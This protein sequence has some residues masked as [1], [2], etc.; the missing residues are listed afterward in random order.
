M[1]TQEDAPIYPSA[2]AAK[3]SAAA[4]RRDE[5][6]SRVRW[7]WGLIGF[8]GGAG[9]HI[10][11]SLAIGAVIVLSNRGQG[12]TQSLL[13]KLM[14]PG[15]LSFQVVLT[16]GILALW[17]LGLPKAL[18]VSVKGFLKLSHA[19]PMAY[20]WSLVG[21]AACGFVVDQ[22]LFLLHNAAPQLFDTEGLAAFGR[23]FA[24]ASLGGY[25]LMTVVV[26]L[27]P[28]LGEE[29][30]FRG[31]VLRSFVSG[32]PAW[33]AVLLSSALFGALHWN[34]LQGVGAAIIG[35][36]LGLVTLLT[37]SLWPAVLAHAVNN[38]ISS[39]YARYSVADSVEVFRQGHPLWLVSAAAVVTVLAVWQLFKAQDTSV[40][41]ADA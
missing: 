6:P 41:A 10:F 37:G 24:G 9:S 18:K 27:G 7:W 1:F 25:V 30:M 19:R 17:A 33:A 32:M 22:V 38:T 16:S 23:S 2:A 28:G 15:W 12:G 5:R 4:G 14:S 21:M 3:S 36:Y 40:N 34:M 31:L 26:A 8:A 29:L 39:L 20:L 35:V 11:L 13:D